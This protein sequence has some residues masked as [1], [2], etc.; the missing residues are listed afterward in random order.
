ML[1]HT[2]TALDGYP[3]KPQLNYNDVKKRKT[4]FLYLLG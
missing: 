1:A 3:S 2:P 4:C